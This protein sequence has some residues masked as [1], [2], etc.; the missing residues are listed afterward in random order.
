MRPFGYEPD[1]TTV[2]E[3]EAEL[4]RD[5][6]QRIV[7]GES[8]RSVTKIL[9]EG[10]ARTSGGNALTPSVLRRILTS[11]R[12]SGRE[13][14]LNGE[15]LRRAD[16]PAI[17]D[18]ATQKRVG[19]VLT[20][21]KR[22]RGGGSRDH[23]V[24]LLTGGLAVC[25][26][27]GKPLVARPQ[28]N[29]KRGYVCASGAP[30]FGC[31]KIRIVADMLEKE[32][33]EQVLGRLLR[34]DAL[35]RLEAAFAEVR[36]RAESAPERIE[37]AQERMRELGEAYAEGRVAAAELQAARASV[38]DQ[39]RTARADVK[40]GESVTNLVALDAEDLAAWWETATLADQRALI[41]TLIDRVE[42]HPVV[43]KG[44]KIFDPTRV[45][46]VWRHS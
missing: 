34:P 43:V 16:W 3:S 26:L 2:R 41:D 40:L 35:T 5:A 22:L 30:T 15:G 23:R 7:D 12:I 13:T 42:V 32:V 8:L 46:I 31:G 4:I 25:G 29:K 21:T 45:R 6:A 38:N 9:N 10:G 19:K 37:R 20:D 14:R 27:C 18:Q 28:N 1:R 33:A 44:S 11:P 39:V 36:A 24:Y 17:I